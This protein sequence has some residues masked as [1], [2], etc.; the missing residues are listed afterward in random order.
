[1][2]ADPLAIEPLDGS[3]QQRVIERSRYYIELAEQLFSIRSKPVDILFDLRGRSVG[4]YRVYSSTRRILGRRKREIRYN[5]FIFAKYFEDN[6]DTTVPHEVAHY[7][8]DLIYGLKNIRPHGE[9]W[10]AIMHAF[11][12]DSK[13]TADYD[14]EGIPRRQQTYHPYLCACRQHQLSTTRHNRIRK[15]RGRYYCQFCQ[16]ILKPA[17]P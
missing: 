14:L 10:K 12:A 3:R 17:E 7:I 4:M 2:E 8:S 13:V 16:Q 11:G 15:R 6:Y 5:P 1:M 9:E